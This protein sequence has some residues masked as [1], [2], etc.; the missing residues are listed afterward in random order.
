MS[1]SSG[2]SIIWIY[3]SF[4]SEALSLKTHWGYGHIGDM[5]VYLGDISNAHNLY[6]YI[7]YM[8]IQ[9]NTHTSP[10]TFIL[11]KY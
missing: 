4:N 8:Y 11:P 9:V 2:V 5:L 6:R 7:R 10:P 1:V 3:C